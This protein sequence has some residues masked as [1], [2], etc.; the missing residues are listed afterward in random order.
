MSVLGDFRSVMKCAEH[1]AR[2]A[3]TEVGPEHVTYAFAQTVGVSDLE[4]RAVLEYGQSRSWERSGGNKRRGCFGAQKAW[5]GG[6]SGGLH[7][8]RE[9]GFRG[10]GGVGSGGGAGENSGGGLSGQK[11]RGCGVSLRRAI[12]N[13]TAAGR[14]TIASV[15]LLLHSQ[16]ELRDLDHAVTEVGG[17][18]EKWLRQHAD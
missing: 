15:L 12:Q 18:L 9:G 14:V 5:R 10:G 13:E 16:G 6:R 17:N 3:Q 11:G 7:E 4:A 2:S 1:A 8:K